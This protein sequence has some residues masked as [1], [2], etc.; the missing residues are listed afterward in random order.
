[1]RY[2]SESR[3]GTQPRG[4]V[5]PNV[6]CKFLFTLLHFFLAVS[7]DC[8]FLSSWFLFFT[9]VSRLL[10]FVILPELCFASCCYFVLPCWF[11]CV[12]HFNFCFVLY[13]VVSSN[14]FCLLHYLVSSS[15]I[16]AI[17]QMAESQ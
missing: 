2:S 1:M 11:G 4:S 5:S 16:T 13:L 14:F 17:H 6:Y 9:L 8:V 10:Q 3:F 7:T 12:F 15:Q